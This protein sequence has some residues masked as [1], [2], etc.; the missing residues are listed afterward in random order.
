MPIFSSGV[1]TMRSTPWTSSRRSTR[2]CLT[3]QQPGHSRVA[4]AA[5]SRPDHLCRAH[6]VVY[7]YFDM[8]TRLVVESSPLPG[9]CSTVI[10]ANELCGNLLLELNR[11]AEAASYFQKALIRTPNRPRLIFGLA[12]AAEI[13]GDRETARPDPPAAPARLRQFRDWLCSQN[14]YVRNRPQH[15][16]GSEAD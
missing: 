12:R 9:F 7:G 13:Q 11:L 6:R 15:E 2:H 10:P 5:C 4:V 3:K 8:L 1:I 16:R 14:T